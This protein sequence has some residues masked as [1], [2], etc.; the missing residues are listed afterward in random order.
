M[1]FLTFLIC[2]ELE[3]ERETR[4]S[5]YA[6]LLYSLFRFF[7]EGGGY[8]KEINNFIFS[9]KTLIESIKI[10]YCI[11]FFFLRVYIYYIS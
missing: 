6:I 7:L 4:Q 5:G 11:L 10:V 1:I 3:R 9:F 2:V 8:V